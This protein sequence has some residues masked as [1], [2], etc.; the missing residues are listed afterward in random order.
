MPWTEHALTSIWWLQ[1]QSRLLECLMVNDV[2]FERTSIGRG[3]SRFLVI[4]VPI[5]DRSIAQIFAQEHIQCSNHVSHHAVPDD[6]DFFESREDVTNLLGCEPAHVTVQR[7][8]RPI[9][10]NTAAA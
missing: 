3:S 5:R 1:K 4:E 2:I 6:N 10:A 7:D 8:E 9:E